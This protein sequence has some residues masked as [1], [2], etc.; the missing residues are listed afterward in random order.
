VEIIYHPSGLLDSLFNVIIISV[1]Q[2]LHLLQYIVIGASVQTS[3]GTPYQSCM[4]WSRT[5]PTNAEQCQTYASRQNNNYRTG[6]WSVIGMQ[7]TKVDIIGCHQG[8]LRALS[9]KHGSTDTRFVSWT[10]YNIFSHVWRHGYN[11]D[12][13]ISWYLYDLKNPFICYVRTG[14]KHISRPWLA[15]PRSVEQ[16]STIHPN[17]AK[18][19]SI[20]WMLSCPQTGY[21]EWFAQVIPRSKLPGLVHNIGVIA[22]LTSCQLW[23]YHH[24][25]KHEHKSTYS[26]L[27]QCDKIYGRAKYGS[28]LKCQ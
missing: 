27:Y 6:N 2:V 25:L 21:L 20:L 11:Y 8:T 19:H 1:W 17:S 9:P 26:S 22:H 5:R 14:V 15:L 18:S 23:C 13:L 3:H 7:W 16:T 4:D 10:S 12:K 24:G 28:N